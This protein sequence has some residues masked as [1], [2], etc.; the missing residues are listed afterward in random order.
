[1]E[2]KA[3]EPAIEN[4]KIRE[5]GKPRISTSTMGAVRAED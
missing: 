2:F 1:M 5:G 4:L 3:N